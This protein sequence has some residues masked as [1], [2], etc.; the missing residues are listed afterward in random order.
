MKLKVCILFPSSFYCILLYSLQ[1]NFPTPSFVYDFFGQP[2]S[3]SVFHFRNA[4]PFTYRWWHQYTLTSRVLQ[5]NSESGLLLQAGVAKSRISSIATRDLWMLYYWIHLLDLNE[6]TNLY[7]VQA[8][9]SRS[10]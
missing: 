8:A 1:Q 9:K 3:C 10:S 7:N 6:Y 5:R 2:T 4:Q